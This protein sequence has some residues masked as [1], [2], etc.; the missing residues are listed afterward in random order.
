MRAQRAHHVVFP[1][2]H[3][4]PLPPPPTSGRRT[5]IARHSSWGRSLLVCP[6][7]RGGVRRS[8]TA[9]GRCRLWVL[10]KPRLFREARAPDAVPEQCPRAAGTE[11]TRRSGP[12]QRTVLKTVG[13]VTTRLVGSNPTPSAENG[14]PSRLGVANAPGAVVHRREDARRRAWRWGSSARAGSGVADAE[15]LGHSV[16]AATK[17]GSLGRPAGPDDRVSD[18]P[19]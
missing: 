9:D 18:S 15:L 17:H 19:R 7:G 12:V 5:S 16:G 8:P 13:R 2:A 14:M 3:P 11:G 10:C 1:D 6:T 4:R